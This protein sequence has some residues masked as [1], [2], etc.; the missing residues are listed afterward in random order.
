MMDGSFLVVMMNSYGYIGVVLG[1]MLEGVIIIIPSELILAFAGILVSQGTFTMTGAIVAGV[2]GS[3][4]CAMVLYC[5]GYFGGRPFI[6]KYGKYFFI[7]S[8]DLAKTEVWFNK[9]GL[10]ASL[11]GRCFPII[12]TLISIP[13]GISKIDWKKFLLYTTIGSIPWTIAFVYAGYKLGEN[14]TII[15]KYVDYLKVPIIICGGLFVI[16]YVYRHLKKKK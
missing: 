8:N 2:I 16:W 11:F 13:M 15:V 1:M 14:Y 7:N 6:E 5:L 12:R 3:D 4:L 10:W 9:Y